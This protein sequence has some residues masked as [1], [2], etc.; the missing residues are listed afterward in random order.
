MKNTL[1]N[2][3]FS[4]KTFCNFVIWLIGYERLII[5]QF[6]YETTKG[7]SMPKCRSTRTKIVHKD[8]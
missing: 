3:Q 4:N 1:K 6:F 7:V 8:K 2:H 5:E